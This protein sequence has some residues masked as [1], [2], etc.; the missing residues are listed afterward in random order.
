MAG[1]EFKDD[2]NNATLFNDVLHVFIRPKSTLYRIL[3]L[4][5]FVSSFVRRSHFDVF[6]SEMLRV[7]IVFSIA[8][9]ESISVD[10]LN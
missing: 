3:G 2:V 9:L 1:D 6:Y 5:N 8:S 7:S 10:Q 4:K